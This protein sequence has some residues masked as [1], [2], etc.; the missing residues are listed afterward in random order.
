VSCPWARLGRTV[1]GIAVFGRGGSTVGL[2]A[3]TCFAIPGIKRCVCFE[4]F[5]EFGEE[6]IAVPS[7]LHKSLGRAQSEPCSHLLRPDAP[8]HIGFARVIPS[9]RSCFSDPKWLKLSYHG[10]QLSTGLG[11]QACDVRLVRDAL[12]YYLR[13]KELC[14]AENGMGLVG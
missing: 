12:R 4:S 2:G 7:S 6:P 8:P 10:L 1:K 9:G 11:R 3:Q 5:P 14:H 13:K